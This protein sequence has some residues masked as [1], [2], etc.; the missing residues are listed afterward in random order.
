MPS[1][2]RRPARLILTAAVLLLVTGCTATPTGSAPTMTVTASG[3]ASASPSATT[4]SARPA[5]DPEPTSTVTPSTD[6]DAPA[7]QCA[8][9]NL[10]VS[11][12]PDVEGN[13][14]EHRGFFVVFQNAGAD[15]C[16]LRGDPGVSLVGRGSGEQLG[17][18]A[19]RGGPS[20][21][22]TVRLAAKGYA[23]AKLDTEQMDAKGGIFADGQGG[24][25]KCRVAKADGYRIYPPHS[26]E[27]V[28][29][30]S[31]GL[32][33]CTTDVHWLTIDEVEPGSRVAGFT[34]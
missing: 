18:A 23:V 16:E 9:A 28:L 3:S 2:A 27:A 30:R 6:P 26:F 24:D 1:P 11:V 20:D 29:V 13:G 4:G 17:A 25:P 15:T 8:D 34:A 12:R 21:P 7:Q 19:E 22:P 33:A 5:A 14:L 10:A 32:Y 31:S